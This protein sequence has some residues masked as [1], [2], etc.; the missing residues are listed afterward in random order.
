[1]CKHSKDIENMFASQRGTEAY[2]RIVATI[3]SENMTSLIEQGL[4]IGFSGGP[5]S[6]F[7][8]CF[9]SEYKRRAGKDFPILAIHINH[10]IRGEEADRDE[11]FSS[12]F[13]SSL[14][15]EF[16]SFKF[17][18]P[19]M[20]DKL[21]LG[22]EETARNVRYSCFNDIIKGRNNLNY[23]AVAH[24]ATDNTETVLMNILRGSGLSGACGIKPV[25]ENIIRPLIKISKKEIVT[26]LDGFSIPY[27]TDSTNH[28]TDYSRNYIRNKILPLLHKLSVDPDASFAKFTDNLRSDLDYL[29]TQAKAFIEANAMTSENLRN[30]HPSIQA[31]VLSLIIF[32]ATGEYPEEKHI[33]AIRKLLQT[34][35]FKYSLPGKYDFICERGICSFSNKILE[36]KLSKQIFSLKKGENRINGTNL[37]VFIGENDKISSNIYNFSIQAQISSDIIDVGLILRFKSDGD[38]Y[39]YHGMTH[40]LKKVFNDRNIPSSERE[41]IPVICDSLG[42]VVVPGMSV[43]D[44][45]KS[46]ISSKNTSITFA[47]SKKQE[48]EIEVFTALQRK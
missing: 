12:A 19:S 27:V 31:K 29:N 2:K 45:A 33:T 1:M 3:N 32:D 24:N 9:L 47:F 15:V 38:S 42:I 22:L 28:S 40:K 5:D 48:D 21:G 25:R 41:F 6:V 46:D 43:R 44:D 34:D 17:D 8:L 35:N 23:I 37:T 36:N 11:S 10:S 16:K 14:G 4:L 18:V 13:V 20:S 7:L 30:L 39:R 26:L